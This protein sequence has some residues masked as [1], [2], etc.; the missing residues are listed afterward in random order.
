MARAFRDSRWTSFSSAI[1]KTTEA[2]ENAPDLELGDEFV[3]KTVGS[4]KLLQKIGEGGCGG[5]YI[6]EQEKPVRRR[7]AFKIIKLGMDTKSVIARFEAGRQ[8]LAMM[9]HPNIARV[10]TRLFFAE[11]PSG[12]CTFQRC[13]LSSTCITTA[14]VAAS[15]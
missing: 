7:V 4:Y 8:A 13:S 5:V 1:K 10:R 6:A 9:G 3:G 12:K 14:A 11:I 15:G 2:V